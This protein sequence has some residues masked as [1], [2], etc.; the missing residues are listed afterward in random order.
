[1]RCARC[2]TSF[3]SVAVGGRVGASG[4]DTRGCNV[5][6]ACFGRPPPAAVVCRDCEE[7]RTRPPTQGYWS[8]L[9]KST[10]ANFGLF[11][12]RKKFSPVPCARLQRWGL[13]TLN[14]HWRR[15][16]PTRNAG[17]VAKF[18][19]SKEVLRAACPRVGRTLPTKCKALPLTRARPSHAGSTCR[20][21]SRRVSA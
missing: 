15:R 21:P 6:W 2:R 1:M 4:V 5:L 8:R 14:Q 19:S 17:S 13:A 9:I 10:R 12:I 20:S 16:C 18:L 11:L 7:P 3:V